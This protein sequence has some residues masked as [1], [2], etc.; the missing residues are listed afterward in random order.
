MSASIKALFIA[1]LLA[2]MTG[3]VSAISLNTL[4]I[5]PSSCLSA[6]EAEAPKL[7]E[8]GNPIVPPVYDENEEEE[9]PDCE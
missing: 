5:D 6:S 1:A 7:D 9:E 4:E 3:P 8:N 2:L